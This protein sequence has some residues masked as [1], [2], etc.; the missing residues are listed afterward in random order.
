MYA[1]RTVARGTIDT[2]IR[3]RRKLYIR[4][5]THALLCKTFTPALPTLV[6]NI[7]DH[8]LIMADL[9]IK[10]FVRP[11]PPTHSFRLTGSIDRP[12][13]IKNI[14]DSQLILNPPSSLEDLLSCYNSTL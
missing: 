8:F 12:S 5:L 1:L 10:P 3:S 6:F 14:L 4:R 7:T 2:R 11:P 9:E 13:F